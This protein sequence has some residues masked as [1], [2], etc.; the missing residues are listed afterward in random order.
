MAKDKSK[1]GVH[2]TDQERSGTTTAASSKKTVCPLTKEQF[3]E[4]GG[5]LKITLGDGGPTIIVEPRE[6]SSGSLGWYG[7]DK[8]TIVVDG[9][10]VKVQVGLNLVLVGSKPGE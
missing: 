3:L 7:N 9:V 2:G 6:F 4:K 1:V 10:P 8:V 5:V